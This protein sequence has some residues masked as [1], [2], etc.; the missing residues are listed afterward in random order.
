VRAHR[1]AQ[2]P[3]LLGLK[4]QLSELALHTIRARLTAGILTQAQRGARALTLPV[5]FVRAPQGRLETM[6][7][8]CSRR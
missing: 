7:S 2:L 3:L 8:R 6:W 1:L 4:G 5:G